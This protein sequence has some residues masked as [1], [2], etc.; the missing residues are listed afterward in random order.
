MSLF[1][2]GGIVFAIG[3]GLLTI[4]RYYPEKLPAKLSARSAKWQ[5]I[6]LI[7]GGVLITV[8]DTLHRLH[9]I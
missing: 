2:S 7:V 8:V 5:G 6:F 1:P 3:V 4:A 9:K